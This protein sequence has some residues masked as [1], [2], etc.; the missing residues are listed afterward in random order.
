MNETISNALETRFAER[1]RNRMQQPETS[2]TSTMQMETRSKN[3]S[4]GAAVA[5]LVIALAACGSNTSTNPGRSAT[6]HVNPE[7]SGGNSTN[8]ADS[9]LVRVNIDGND[10]SRAQSV[11][12]G[13]DEKTGLYYHIQFDSNQRRTAHLPEPRSYPGLLHT[14]LWASAAADSS[15]TCSSHVLRC[16][17]TGASL[18]GLVVRTTYFRRIRWVRAHVSDSFE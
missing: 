18:A 10:F 11:S 16:L 4:A 12:C 8:T 5:I 15:N 3:S 9:D 13:L 7:N 2:R 6:V 17:F 14:R 1:S